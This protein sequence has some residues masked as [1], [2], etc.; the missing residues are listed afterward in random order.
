MNKAFAISKPLEKWKIR[1]QKILRERYENMRQILSCYYKIAH[2]GS[3]YGYFFS[4]WDDSQNRPAMK[5]VDIENIERHYWMNLPGGDDLWWDALEAPASSG[6]P[7]VNQASNRHLLLHH[8]RD[9]QDNLQMY[10]TSH[11]LMPDWTEAERHSSG[12]LWDSNL[13]DFSYLYSTTRPHPTV[14]HGGTMSPREGKLMEV[15][16][17]IVDRKEARPSTVSGVRRSR[18]A[19]E[20]RRSDR[21]LPPLQ[22][23]LQQKWR[24]PPVSRRSSR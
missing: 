4:L 1:R 16:M 3:M 13:D 6:V 9:V 7:V 18:D 24:R 22:Q 17:R 2:E 5:D 23:S 21:I 19:E 8:N 20:A 12:A 15:P 14:H 11:H 10:G